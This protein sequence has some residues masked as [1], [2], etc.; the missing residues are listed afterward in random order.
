MPPCPLLPCFTKALSFPPLSL[1]LG[2]PEWLNLSPGF[3]IVP[4]TWGGAQLE[5]PSTSRLPEGTAA[6]GFSRN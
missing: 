2:F 1:S 6:V 3:G 4:A 5:A